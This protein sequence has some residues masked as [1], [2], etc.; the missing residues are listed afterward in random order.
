M[1]GTVWREG[2]KGN[3]VRIRVQMGRTSGHSSRQLGRYSNIP[4]T[5]ICL[6]FWICQSSSGS[7][8]GRPRL[9]W[10]MP[11]PDEPSESHVLRVRLANPEQDGPAYIQMQRHQ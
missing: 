1:V 9:G 10:Y 8:Q 3:L 2:L 11:V 6:L 5:C 7:T 4:H